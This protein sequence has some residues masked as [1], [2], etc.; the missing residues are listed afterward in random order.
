MRW[1]KVNAL[2]TDDVLGV[3]ASMITQ[4]LAGEDLD[5]L[6]LL[7][8]DDDT[9]RNR[10]EHDTMA[11]AMALSAMAASVVKGLAAVSDDETPADVWRRIMLEATWRADQ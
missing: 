7:S 9:G 5:V 1:R 6:R 11:I 4:S 3:A 10:P 2:G 8:L